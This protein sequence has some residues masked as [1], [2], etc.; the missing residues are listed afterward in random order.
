MASPSKNWSDIGD[1]RVDADSPLDTTLMTEIRD[2]LV[3]LKEWLGSSFTPAVD[4]DHDGINSKSPV[5]A[6]S[7]VTLSKLKV[8]EGSWSSTGTGDVDVYISIANY[9]HKPKVR[10]VTDSY[11]T[12]RGVKLTEEWE[13]SGYS[14]D[15]GKKQTIRI[16]TTNKQPNDIWYVYWDYHAN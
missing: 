7:T 4:H 15:T 8:A 10:W 6:D 5:L 14:Y 13:Q 11:S 2:N 1:S 12:V 9:S 16:Q 3:H